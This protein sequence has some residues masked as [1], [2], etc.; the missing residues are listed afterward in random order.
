MPIYDKNGNPI[1]DKRQQRAYSMK[2]IANA[3]YQTVGDLKDGGLSIPRLIT[4]EF[5]EDGRKMFLA[6]DEETQAKVEKMLADGGG[7]VVKETDKEKVFTQPKEVEV[8][9]TDAPSAPESTAVTE[10]KPV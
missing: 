2:K 5:D 3:L 10:T 6:T 7:K 8:K 9:P 4:L 1:L